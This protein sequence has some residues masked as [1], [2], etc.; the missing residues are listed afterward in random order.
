[1]I[2]CKIYQYP[3]AFFTTLSILFFGCKKYLD[4]LPRGISVAKTTTD[5]RKLMDDVDNQRYPFSL[6]QT[7]AWVDALSDDMYADSAKWLTFTT[8][9][10]HVKNLY[11]FESDVW[12]YD[13]LVDD[14][15]WK[16]QYYIVSLMGTILL[17][18]EKVT[19]NPVLKKQLVAEARV[20]RA[21]AYLNLVNVYAKH[22]NAQTASSDKGIPMYEDAS[23]L[24]ALNRASV[25]QVYDYI[26]AELNK[27]LP[28]LPDD[29]TSYAH[30]PSKAAA[31]AILARSYLYMGNYPE[32]FI[33][34]EKVL[35]IRDFLNDY[36]TLYTGTIDLTTYLVGMSRTTDN[37]VIL[38]KT[39]SKGVLLNTYMQLDTTS[40][41]LLYPGYVV[42]T[43]AKVDNYD[44]RRTLK[45]TGFNT[46]GKMT[47][48]VVT[49]NKTY[50]TW[51]K[52]DG[53]NSSQADNIHIGT[54][55]MYLIRAECNARAGQLQKALD[56]I[57]LIRLKRFKTGTY[58][59]KT[60]ADFGSNQQ[61]VL[62]E[63]LTER[64]RELYGME[65]R[66]FDI[67]RLNLPLTRYIGSYRIDVPA[68]DPRF[69]WPIFTGY[70]DMNPE[71][72][73]NPR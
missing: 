57:N 46:A 51:Y 13:A 62:Q 29:Y 37:E 68:G 38:H 63:V 12:T 9:R 50:N 33:N 31:H 20:H 66:T 15:T 67:K 72:E 70:I 23:S 22:Y 69:V 59:N 17:E 16:N 21:Y 11:A 49:Y 36:N 60:L 2:Q 10:E 3:I 34:A 35:V 65:L 19:D 5:F 47:G 56:D 28:D 18:I 42:V 30:R 39:T 71:L 40:F 64:R 14:I 53:S 27:A 58:T 48:K 1:M 8:T 6:S 4:V 32:A 25:Q 41:N 52:K 7:T 44:L 24:P 54:P 45:F 43:V 26:I 61:A 73:Q 55:E